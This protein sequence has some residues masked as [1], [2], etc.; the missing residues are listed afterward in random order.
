VA[1][2]G[3]ARKSVRPIVYLGQNWLTRAG[4]ALTTSAALTMLAFWTRDL[5]SERPSHPYEGI[6]LFLVLPGLFVFG[7]ALMPIGIGWRRRELRRAGALPSDYPPVALDLAHVR[8]ALAV[9]AALTVVNLA[10]VATASYKGVEYMD[11][12]QFCGLT[13]HK[14]MAP[15]YT[16]FVGSPHARVGCVGCHI[17]PGASW[18]VKSKLS[19]VRQVFAVALDTYSRPIPSPVE[20]LR[21]A[22]E[23]CEQC[24]WPDRFVGDRFR[25][26]RT[27][28]D[29]EQ[30]TPSTTVL[31]LK[32]GGRGPDGSAGIHGRHV[33]EHVRVTYSA[34]DRKR[35]VIPRM[36]VT[37]ADG[38]SDEFVSSDP[39]PSPDPAGGETRVMDCLD[40]HNRPAHT[41]Q[42]PERAVD[43][44][45]AAGRISATLPFVKKKAVEVLRAEYADG[46]TA[47]R[48]I[49]EDLR[50]FYASGPSAIPADRRGE[51]DAAIGEVQ[52]IYGRNV[53]PHMKVT[54]GTYP[55]HLGH[56]DFTGCFRCHDE[57]HQRADGTT[58]T[59]DCTVCHTMLAQD[60]RDPK[61][62][63]TFGLE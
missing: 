10:L 25:V 18:F 15:Q 26:F 56:Q 35:E 58:I 12:N 59:Q 57:S 44:A 4:A 32:V 62:L 24:H 40:C 36:T 41:F 50:T 9:V 34:A 27:Y 21:P 39:A 38:K 46:D 31:V 52:A 5:L 60:E 23:T 13:C 8:R 22:R 47:A 49:A 43:E 7:L 54:W 33:G 51:I 20:Q 1:V 28:A 2:A 55:N 37:R 16:A 63:A 30:N 61:V 14:V 48:R 45:L 19:G 29:D 11:S 42:L 53:F 6:L 17:G 3:G